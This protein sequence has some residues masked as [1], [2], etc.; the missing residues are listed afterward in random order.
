M[1]KLVSEFQPAG[2]VIDPITNLTSVGDTGRDQGDADAGDRLPEEPGHHR[3]FHQP[4]RRRQRLEQSEVGISSLMDTWLLLRMIETAGERNRLL[5]VLKSRGMAHS[6]QMREFLLTDEGIE[7]LDVYIGPGT[8]LTGSARLVQEA[9]E[10]VQAVCRAAGDRPP[11]ARTGAGADAG[12][13][14]VGRPA[15]QDGLAG[16]RDPNPRKGRRDPGDHD[17]LGA[18]GTG[19]RPGRKYRRGHDEERKQELCPLRPIETPRQRAAHPAD[20]RRG[21]CGCTWPARRPA[22]LQ[23]WRTSRESVR[24]TWRASTRSK[25]WICC[26]IRNWRRGDQILAVPTLVRKLPEPVR[27]II[28]DLSNEERVLVG[29]DLR[30]R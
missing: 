7:L 25:S 29:L 27:K 19:P 13:G 23:P 15:T 4:D 16:R 9:Q 21:N 6:N 8:V 12:P 5:Y 2:V 1:H 14:A 24:S 10:Q 28:G 22:R 18:G 3:L 17:R 20:R 26:G 30:P 11:A